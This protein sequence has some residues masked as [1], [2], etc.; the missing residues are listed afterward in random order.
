MCVWVG[1]Q[2]LTPHTQKKLIENN[3]DKI[4]PLALVFQ[5]QLAT[6]LSFDFSGRGGLTIF[7]RED[8]NY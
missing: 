1:D 2:I 3:R 4:S 6:K 7:I 5:E 8:S